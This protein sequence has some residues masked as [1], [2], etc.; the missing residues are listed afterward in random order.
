MSEPEVTKATSPEGKW[1]MSLRKT[2]Q[3][4]E[5]HVYIG[6][7]KIAEIGFR[8]GASKWNCFTRLF[9]FQIKDYESMN[10]ALRDLHRMLKSPPPEEANVGGE[11]N[12]D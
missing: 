3:P 9:G 12:A 1:V 8:R 11:R 6:A 4:T 2:S 10:E 5:F 7:V